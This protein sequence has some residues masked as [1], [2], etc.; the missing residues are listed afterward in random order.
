MGTS[1]RAAAHDLPGSPPMAD[2]PAYGCS[3]QA[4]TFPRDPAAPEPVVEVIA[5]E[6][7][8]SGFGLVLTQG[9]GPALFRV[10]AVLSVADAQTL[11]AALGDYL[12][13]EASL[14]GPA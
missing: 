1:I 10:A 11:H 2:H 12:D 3:F 9:D 14:A 4:K 5:Y 13:R 8:G 6:V 7:K